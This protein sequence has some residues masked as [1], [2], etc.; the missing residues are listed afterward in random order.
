MDDELGWIKAGDGVVY[1]N[2]VV[3][4]IDGETDG[5]ADGIQVDVEGWFINVIEVF[6]ALFTVFVGVEPC[7]I[8]T[9]GFWFKFSDS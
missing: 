1:V 2:V 8:E 6:G 7:W 3:G 5:V 4:T 9:T